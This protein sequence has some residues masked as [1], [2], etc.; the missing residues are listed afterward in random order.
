MPGLSGRETNGVRYTWAFPTMTFAA[1]T[2]ALWVYEAYPLG[3]DRCRVVQ[4]ACFPPETLAG[5]GADAK[6]A[7]YHDRLDAALDEDIPALINQHR[8]LTN[9]DATQGRFQPLLEPSVAAFARW[10]SAEL[11]DR[12]PHQGVPHS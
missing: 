6:L 7:A 3:A 11:G 5:D 9:P 8:G 10:Y 12:E 4:S 2:D 1:G